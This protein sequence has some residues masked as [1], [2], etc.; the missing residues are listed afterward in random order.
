M[1]S[2]KDAERLAAKLTTT[3]SGYDEPD[4][5]SSALAKFLSGYQPEAINPVISSVIYSSCKRIEAA[6]AFMSLLDIREL[7]KTVPDWNWAE[8]EESFRGSG[9]DEVWSLFRELPSEAAKFVRA[10]VS[11]LIEVFHILIED[12]LLDPETDMECNGALIAMKILKGPDRE[13][14]RFSIKLSSYPV[15]VRKFLKG[16]LAEMDFIERTPGIWEFTISTN[17]L[18]KY[19]TSSNLQSHL[20]SGKMS[21]AIAQR[22]A[23]N[24][25]KRLEL[26]VKTLQMFPSGHPSVDPSTESFL[27]ILER[28]FNEKDQVTISIMGD[29]VMVNDI[30]IEKKGPSL[31]SF[32]RAFAERKMN[33][34][35]FDQ[36][37]TGEDVKT[38]ARIFNRPPA[39]IS[40]HGG[41][42]RLVELRGLDAISI[43][44][45]HY[46]LV[47]EDGD[48]ESTLARGE[49]T[50]E[51]AIFSE[52]I[53]RLERGDSIDSL[54]GSK[55]G[56]ALKSVL[57]AARD[58]REEQ[59]SMIARFV[60]ALDPTLL[61]KGL[62]SSK[63]IQKGMAWKAIRK[64]IDRLLPNLS[65]Q[66]PDVRHNSVNKL[67]DMAL[68][69]VERGKENSTLQIIE[70]LSLLLKR[71]QDP[72]VFYGA[73]V[74]M[75]S[76]MEALLARGMMSIALQAGKVVQSLEKKRF[77][78][79]EMEA[80]RKRA[81]AEAGK[82]ID[83]LEAAEALVQKILSE[84]ETVSAEAR[85]LA[86]IA[87]PE[88][89]VTQLIKIFHEDNRRLRSKAFQMLLRMG[90]RAL[91]AI[92]K[93]LRETVFAFKADGEELDGMINET[94]WYKA[95]NMIQ[96][97]RN[98]GS[99][100][101][102]GILA[103]LCKVP[104]PR[105]R[106]ECLLALIK[107]SSTTAEGLAMHLVLDSNR[108]VAEIALGI[109]TK[110]AS[111]NPVFIPK[112]I[113]AFD[114]NGSIRN[115]VMDSF[116]ILGK[117]WQVIDF[118]TDRISRGTDSLLLQDPELAS[119]AFR[120]IRRYGSPSE[121]P[122]LEH[123]RDE[124]EGGFLKK[125][126]IDRGLIQQLK[127][128]MEA[129]ESSGDVIESSARPQPAPPPTE[130]K[131]DVPKPGNKKK[132]KTQ[133]NDDDEEITILGP[134]F[135]G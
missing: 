40:E 64:I 34:L 50:V 58:N 118:L 31:G 33:S 88:N 11:M 96:A 47:S 59:R 3:I 129:L 127:E 42:A 62:L 90:D 37:I 25:V 97:L 46:Q 82:K 101:S 120:I 68:L 79:T 113:E 112:I 77:S 63:V 98:I 43:N 57:A 49:V 1:Q 102:E 121:L 94:D 56:S 117:H 30:S 126:K 53:D 87:P 39:Y 38:F 22:N 103:E 48:E 132:P 23:E 114:R 69:A 119:G 35:S 4:E 110:R 67:K 41:M 99:P 21:Q 18:K 104:D 131:T 100:D 135:I 76:I 24:L 116:S 83:T 13:A 8:L 2:T 78:R 32:I 15:G 72:D 91:S 60:T 27:G 75:A 92:H 61:E 66:D 85:R 105:I 71:E 125:N 95:R 6:L 14:N 108:D 122:V 130:K 10:K 86:M 73:A 51:D 107:V 36:G 128:T 52:L 45:Y 26:L 5:R 124:V 12:D 133:N 20:G 29:T 109:L 123:L 80:A 54:P 28:F 9:M 81:L 89:L 111:G 106:R 74:L 65:S 93:K 17:S 19:A 55:I 115:E 84:D 44:R 16:M 134:D 70:N 7:K